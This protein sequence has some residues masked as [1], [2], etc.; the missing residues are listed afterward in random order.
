MS[1]FSLV[2]VTGSNVVD[3]GVFEAPANTTC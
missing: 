3:D 2:V 1:S